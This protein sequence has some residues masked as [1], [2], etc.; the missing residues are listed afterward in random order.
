M[1]ITP[2][3]NND[4]DQSLV[5]AEVLKGCGFGRHFGVPTANMNL[6]LEWGIYT[7]VTQFGPIIIYSHGKD[8]LKSRNME[9]SMKLDMLMPCMRNKGLAEGFIVGFSGDLYGKTLEI[10]N[11][12]Q[13]PEQYI[14]FISAFVCNFD[15]RRFCNER[16]LDVWPALGTTKGLNIYFSPFMWKLTISV[17]VFLVSLCVIC[18][19]FLFK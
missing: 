16:W 5:K 13:I 15:H 1:S 7:G 10:K 12:Q 8:Q 11:L 2:A 17:L 18:F 14:N 6:D 3:S 19:Y 9:K 4:A